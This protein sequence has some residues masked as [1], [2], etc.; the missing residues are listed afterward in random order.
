MLRLYGELCITV[1]LTAT[2]D[3]RT[4]SLPT[5]TALLP[6]V[7]RATLAAEWVITLDTSCSVQTGIRGA[8]AGSWKKE[9]WQGNRSNTL[10]L[11]KKHKC[12]INTAV[13][14]FYPR[15]FRIWNG[16]PPHIT[17]I[18]NPVAFQ[19]RTSPSRHP[20]AYFPVKQTNKQINKHAYIL[21][22][23]YAQEALQSPALAQICA[24]WSKLPE[25]WDNALV[26]VCKSFTDML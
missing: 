9:L 2:K 6:H 8:T 7:T 16:I 14:S 5:C 13:L 11:Y 22:N 4:C 25:T 21:P 18:E 17:E 23:T 15:A 24:V 10:L 12:R 26:Q 3:K 19:S 20:I 1:F